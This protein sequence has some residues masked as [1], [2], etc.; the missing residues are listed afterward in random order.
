MYAASGKHL[1]IME[2]L[3]GQP[4]IDINSR[5][6][7]IL[8]GGTPLHWAISGGDSKLVEMLL[9]QPNLESL[10][11][12]DIHGYTPLIIQTGSRFRGNYISV[13]LELTDDTL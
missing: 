5:D 1:D 4:D 13:G 11:S 7:S 8:V 9:K 3:L 2:L 10:E 6:D 12:Q